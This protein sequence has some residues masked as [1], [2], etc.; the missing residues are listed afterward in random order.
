MS[1][2]FSIFVIS[3]YIQL[4]SSFL[5]E[6]LTLA[7]SLSKLQYTVSDEMGS[8]RELGEALEGLC[9]WRPNQKMSFDS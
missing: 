6:K 3:P 8:L 2:I 7:L 1:N 9:F 5:T 4:D